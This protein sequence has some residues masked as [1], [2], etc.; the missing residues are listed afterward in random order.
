MT[1]TMTIVWLICTSVCD[2]SRPGDALM[3]LRSSTAPA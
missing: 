2:S 3:V 1:I